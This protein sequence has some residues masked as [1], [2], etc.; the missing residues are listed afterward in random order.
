[1]KKE[2]QN[3]YSFL[4]DNLKCGDGKYYIIEEINNKSYIKKV[5]IEKNGSF[6]VL[7]QKDQFKAELFKDAIPSCDFIVVSYDKVYFVELKST[8][9]D[10]IYNNDENPRD[11]ALKQCKNSQLLF[12]YLYSAYNLHKSAN[13][14]FENKQ[15]IYLYPKRAISEKSPTNMD[16]KNSS[17]IPKEVECDNN[18]CIE[19]DLDFFKKIG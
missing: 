11:K 15:F 7:K 9:G 4:S 3:F 17:L 10:T 18:G 19:L 1:M 5:S 14:N 16:T 13:L 12:D 6:F 2:L 8:S